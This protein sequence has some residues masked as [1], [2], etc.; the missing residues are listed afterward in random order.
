M[1]EDLEREIQRNEETYFDS[2]LHAISEHLPFYSK[3][4]KLHITSGNLIL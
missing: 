1:E 2:K 4:D 3:K